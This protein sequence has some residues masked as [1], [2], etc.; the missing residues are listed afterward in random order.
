[1]CCST[2]GR[3]YNSCPKSP[4][5]R[6][7]LQQHSSRVRFHCQIREFFANAHVWNYS[8]SLISRTFLLVPVIYGFLNNMHSTYGPCILTYPDCISF[9]QV[10]LRIFDLCETMNRFC[11]TIIGDY[12]MLKKYILFFQFSM[13]DM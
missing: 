12:R 6:G 11:P 13:R 3:G 2:N 8:P 7:H 1:M 4:S 10:K 5:I 9:P